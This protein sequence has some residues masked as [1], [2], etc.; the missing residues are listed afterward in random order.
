MS[1]SGHQE[2][3][4]NQKIPWV[5]SCQSSSSEVH[6]GGRRSLES[7]SQAYREMAVPPAPRPFLKTELDSHIM[8][9]QGTAPTGQTTPRTAARHAQEGTTWGQELACS[10]HPCHPKSCMEISIYR[11]IIFHI[12]RI[13]QTIFLEQF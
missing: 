6:T 5:H 1:A 13:F 3:H 12:Y 4:L 7:T 10:E 2:P 11:S 9:N 8:C